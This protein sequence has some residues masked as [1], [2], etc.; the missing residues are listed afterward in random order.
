MKHLFTTLALAAALLA[1]L[2][3]ADA[4]LDALINQLRSQ[5]YSNAV[6]KLYQKRLLSVL[7]SISAGASVDTIIPNANGTT[8]LHNACGLSHVEIVRWLVNNGANTK[9]KTAKGASVGM[10]VGPPNA[11]A[12]N[13]ILQSPPEKKKSVAG[14][15][16]APASV[17][18]KRF[19]FY[20]NA[21]DPA[22]GHGYTFNKGNTDI[23]SNEIDP[24][25]GNSIEY[26]KTGPNTA[27]IEVLEWESM[28]TY[29][30][31]FTSPTE[32]LAICTSEGDCDEVTARL[33][34]LIQ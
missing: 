4:E 11:K 15:G 20:A 2:A 26:K 10:C 3:H 16:Y 6:Q 28:H 14:S 9:A 30:L 18:G 31:T 19:R 5:K 22:T 17:K 29:I 24:H 21:E 13:K 34:F 27:R 33:F 1:P 32:G 23:L 12:I 7:P 8:A 25:Y